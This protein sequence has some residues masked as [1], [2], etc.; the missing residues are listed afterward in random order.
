MATMQS[1][2]FVKI[3]TRT[4]VQSYLYQKYLHK[5][6]VEYDQSTKFDI[7]EYPNR[8]SYKELHEDSNIFTYLS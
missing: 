5:Q 8:Y 1:V 2:T 6:I 4:N 7:S 3:L